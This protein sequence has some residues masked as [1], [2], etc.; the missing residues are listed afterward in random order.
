[1]DIQRD[2]QRLVTIGG[3]GGSFVGPA[4]LVGFGGMNRHQ[5]TSTTTETIDDTTVVVNGVTQTI[6]GGTQTL[7]Q[8]TEGWNWIAGGGVEAWLTGRVA[9]YG[10]FMLAKVKGGPISGGEGGIDS[11]ATFVV[12]GARVRLG[13]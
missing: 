7:A 3:R 1:M 12:V 2:A 10:E 6:K 8:K 11:K 9:F 4:G 13:G 5:A